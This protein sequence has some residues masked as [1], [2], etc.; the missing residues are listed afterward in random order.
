MTFTGTGALSLSMLLALTSA[1]TGMWY[2]WL[3][4][5]AVSWLI[6]E[7]SVIFYAHLRGVKNIQEWTLSDTI[8]RW[9]AVHRWLA[10]LTVGTCAFLLVHFFGMGNL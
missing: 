5:V 7:L 10:P 6:L 3:V 4:G 1:F 8:R 2:W 9:S